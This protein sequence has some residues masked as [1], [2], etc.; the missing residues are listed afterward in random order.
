[1]LE[2]ELSK[3]GVAWSRRAV[4]VADVGSFDGAFLTNARGI[5]PVGRIDDTAMP[6]DAEPVATVIRTFEAAPWDPI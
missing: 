2:R 5:A 1:M 3:A 6:A 4:N